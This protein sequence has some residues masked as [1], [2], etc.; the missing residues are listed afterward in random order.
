MNS[1]HPVNGNT[2]TASANQPKQDSLPTD[3]ER[4]AEIDA[5]TA[6]DLA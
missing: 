1:P 6:F 2:A 4:V 5:P 3:R